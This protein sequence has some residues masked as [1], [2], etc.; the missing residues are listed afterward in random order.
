[1]RPLPEPPSDQHIGLVRRHQGLW[2]TSPAIWRA[3]ADFPM[4]SLPMALV[5]RIHCVAD[6]FWKVHGRCVAFTLML[7]PAAL[8]WSAV[9]PMQH[10]GPT[11]AIWDL[12]RHDYLEL[13]PHVFAGSF[14]TAHIDGVFAA[15]ELV[16]PEDGLHLIFARQPDPK[17]GLFFLRIEGEAAL[18]NPSELLVDDYDHWVLQYHNRF[19]L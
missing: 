19:Q 13:R 1:M 16:P 14:Q 11:R 5:S 3:F 7:D 18:A 17:R 12:R 6:Q 15:A 9:P 4:P 10:C 8:I 2:I